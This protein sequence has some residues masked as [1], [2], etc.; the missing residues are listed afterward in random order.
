MSNYD[1]R[2]ENNEDYVWIKKQPG[3]FTLDFLKGK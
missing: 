2:I 1:L 3:I